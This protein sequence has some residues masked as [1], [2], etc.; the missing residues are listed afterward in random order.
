MSKI[1]NDM[2]LIDK[3]KP[4]ERNYKEHPEYQIKQ[5]K[6]SHQRFGQYRSVVLWERPGGYY[7]QVAGHGF[8]EAMKRDGAKD[9]RADI[10]SEDTSQDEVDAIL[11]A[12]NLH[13]EN[14]SD[15]EWLLSEL[16][17]EQ[18]EA[19][20][21]LQSLGYS[22]AQLEELIG[23]LQPPT[24]EEIAKQYGGESKE[25]DFWPTIRL[26]VPPETKACFDDL[27]E[28]SQGQNDAERFAFLLSLLATE[29]VSGETTS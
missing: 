4:H 26:K 29:E 23:K 17:V 20:Y 15:N 12:D 11:L 9:V 5:L 16:L 3:I 19:G 21:D 27:M 7:I 2:V 1:R 10:L 22:E 28:G 24:F 14:S 13:A 25:E 18:K 8:L 6:Q